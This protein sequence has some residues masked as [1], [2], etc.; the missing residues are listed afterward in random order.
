MADLK[1][2]YELMKEAHRERVTKTPDRVAYAIE[3]FEKNG[4]KYELKSPETGHFHCWR[5]SDGR[6]FQFYAGTG[7]IIGPLG[8]RMHSRGIHTLIK[9]LAKGYL[10]ANEGEQE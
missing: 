3:Q 8:L 6:L 9:V 1:E 10:D 2:E 7:K 5:K 4:I